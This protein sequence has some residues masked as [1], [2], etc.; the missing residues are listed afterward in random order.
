MKGENYFYLGGRL[1]VQIGEERL[2][3][4]IVSLAETFCQ[5]SVTQREE[6][7]NTTANPMVRWCLCGQLHVEDKIG[8]MSSCCKHTPSLCCPVQWA[9]VTCLYYLLWHFCWE[10]PQHWCIR[11]QYLAC[12]NNIM[13]RVRQI[14]IQIHQFPG[15]EVASLSFSDWPF[16]DLESELCNANWAPTWVY[17]S[18]GLES[19]VTM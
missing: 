6:H 12:Y 9:H 4:K 11:M 1:A 18:S 15:L 2:E 5:F 17:I 3:N 14:V 7:G 16:P 13:L 10:Q 19:C 8:G